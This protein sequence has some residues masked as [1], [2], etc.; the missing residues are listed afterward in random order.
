MRK[1]LAGMILVMVMLCTCAHAD[2]VYLTD[3]GEMGLVQLNG[4]KSSDLV[5]TLYTTSWSSPFLGSYWNGSSTRIIL[6]DRT[7][8]TTTSGD[9]AYTFDPSNLT[10]PLEIS[11]RVLDGVYSAQAFAGSENGRAVFFASGNSIREFSTSDFSLTRSYTYRPKTSEDIS[12]EIT[13]LITGTN[14]IYALVQQEN[15]RDVVLEFD[16]QLRDDVS[17]F[18]NRPLS[19]DT[20]VIAWLEDT[21]VA[22]GH[23]YGVDVK[24]NDGR[25]VLTL[26]TDVPVKAVCQDSGSGFY[27]IEQY[28]YEGVYTT[29]L[30]HYSSGKVYALFTNTEGRAC[31]LVRDKD[32]GIIGALAGD[33]IL[34]YRM[35]DDEL[36]GEYDSILLGGL[37]EQIAVSNVTGSDKK[38]NSGCRISLSG[39]GMMLLLAGMC[40][41]SKKQH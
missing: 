31:R 7:A 22:A 17:S 23:E 5:G 12:S 11:R 13:G 36:L 28:E 8:D 32:N 25:F 26:S 1:F 41:L 4:S 29:E 27:F 40:T 20:E 37:P 3:S 35:E 10:Q 16:G 38:S 21:R 18:R 2:I 24:L 6:V 9:T 33:T 30:K 15:S 39:M 14:V 34:V 19:H